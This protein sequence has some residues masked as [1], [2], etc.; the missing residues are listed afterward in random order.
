MNV[1]KVFL[2]GRL[3]RE[4][5]VRFAQS[6]T[7][8]CQFGAAVD[9]QVK[10]GDTWAKEPVFVDVTI[11]GKRAEA[12]AKHHKK[13][14]QFFVEGELCFEQWEDKNGGGKRSKLKVIAHEWQFCGS[15]PAEA[16]GG[17]VVN[18]PA[19]GADDVPF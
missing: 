14:D 16:H 13:G 6:G 15:K 9:R 12:F 2:A 17:P 5:E 11:F 18:L 4:P 19:A 3:T 10:K 7:A 1:N 8:V